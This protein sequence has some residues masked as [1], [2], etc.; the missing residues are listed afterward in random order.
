MRLVFALAVFLCLPT[1]AAEEWVLSSRGY[2][3]VRAGM[4]VTQAEALM[5]TAL[6]AY[7]EM[8]FDPDCDYVYPRNGHKGISL[9][10]QG[11]RIAH[12]RVISAGVTT[13]SGVRVGDAAFKLKRL[14]PRV[15]I[16]EH[17]YVD[18]YYCFVWDRDRRNGVK[19]V[20]VDD[21]VQEIHTGNASIRLVEGCA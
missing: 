20:V 13:K 5:G 18:G 4:T 14:F 15:E 12:I 3:P 17:K 7:N 2:G 1:Q 8:P 16:E 6:R 9:M 11:N 21:K 10:V 19:F